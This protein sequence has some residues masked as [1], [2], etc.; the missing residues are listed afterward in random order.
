MGRV[1]NGFI[2]VLI[3][4]NAIAFAADTVPDLA[5]PGICTGFIR[6]IFACSGCFGYFRLLMLVRY[7]PALQTLGRVVSMNIGRCSACFSSF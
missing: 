4:L 6:W 5:E 1:V 3:F 2:I 7:S